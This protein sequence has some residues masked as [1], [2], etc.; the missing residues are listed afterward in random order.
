MGASFSDPYIYTYNLL[1]LK[2]GKHLEKTQD[3][4]PLPNLMC[5]LLPMMWLT[6]KLHSL[7]SLALVFFTSLPSDNTLII[8]GSCVHELSLYYYVYFYLLKYSINAE[9]L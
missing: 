3:T 5:L 1:P 6:G 4:T 7:Q 9:G 2:F 8:W